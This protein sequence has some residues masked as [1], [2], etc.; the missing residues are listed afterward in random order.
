[1]QGGVRRPYRVEY[2]PAKAF[3]KHGSSD[4]PDLYR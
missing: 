4:K 3:R 2:S 1:M